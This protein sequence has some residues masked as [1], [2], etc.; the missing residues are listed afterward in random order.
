MLAWLQ[1]RRQRAQS[2]LTADQRVQRLPSADLG[3]PAGSQSTGLA[4][5]PLRVLARM[6]K[7]PRDN[8]TAT[9]RPL[10]QGP[11][12]A[13]VPRL[14]HLHPRAQADLPP[15]L[16]CWAVA[17][18][19]FQSSLNSSAPATHPLIPSLSLAPKLGTGGIYSAFNRVP[20]GAEAV[21]ARAWPTLPGPRP[22][23]STRTPSCVHPALAPAP[24]PASQRWSGAAKRKG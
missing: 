19:N 18:L 24:P 13:M 3:P 11:A 15:A 16:G 8:G 2:E 7:A 21:P 22:P 14:G 4:G 9:Q 17:R 6:P 5:L 10:A 1:A 12:C 20:E 23:T